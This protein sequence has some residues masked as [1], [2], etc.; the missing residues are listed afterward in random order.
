[1]I[2]EKTVELVH[3]IVK[4]H[5]IIPSKVHNVV[6]GLGYSGVELASFTHGMFLGVANTLPDFIF[7]E[8]CSKL[9]SA[10]KLSEMPLN[11]LLQWS[12]SAPSLKKI[13]GIAAL[14]A[15]SQH[16]LAIKNPYKEVKQNLPQFLK[17]NADTKVTFIGLIGPLIKSF[18][19]KTKKVSI[20]ENNL[21]FTQEFKKFD[22]KTSVDEVKESEIETDVLVCTGTALINDTLEDILK[23]YNKNAGK[24]VVIGPTAGLLPDILFDY[25]ADLVGGMR[26]SDTESAIKVLQQAGGTKIFKQYAEKYLLTRE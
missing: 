11:E 3:Q 23:I 20:I 17:V 22:T 25:G 6:V 12:F 14:N 5:K 9:K 24:I 4:F 1:M 18:S 26:F 13:V 10:G 2:L 8:T 16:I 15:Y 7:G 21:E 19:Q